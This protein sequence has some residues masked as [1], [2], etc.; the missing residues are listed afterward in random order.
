METPDQP[1]SHLVRWTEDRRRIASVLHD[2]VIQ[3]MS[4]ALMAI[5]IARM[6]QPDDPN[7]SDAENA[8]ASS[9]TSLRELIQDLVNEPDAT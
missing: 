3:T 4:S 9:A 8:L 6:D 5:G 2:D 7:L 1:A